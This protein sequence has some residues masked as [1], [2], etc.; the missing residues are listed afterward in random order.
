MRDR[1]RKIENTRGTEIAIFTWAR[2]YSLYVILGLVLTR[3]GE[4][5]RHRNDGQEDSFTHIS[6]EAGSM[7][8]RATQGGTGLGLVTGGAGAKT[9]TRASLCFPQEGVG[10]GG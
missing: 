10:E 7:A 3:Y 8:Q 9:W 2:P 6:L 1:E 5:G 4:T